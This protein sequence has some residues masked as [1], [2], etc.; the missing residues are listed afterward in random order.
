[1]SPRLSLPRLVAGLRAWTRFHDAHVRSAVEL[2]IGHETW[3]R[4]AE[5]RSACLHLDDDGEVWI[6]FQAAA[7]ARAAGEFAA[8]SSTER[9]VLDLAVARGTD[10]YRFSAMGPANRDLIIRAVRASLGCTPG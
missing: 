6:D 1:M 10:R 9:A 3:L 2:L 5:F 4:R 8:S 7:A